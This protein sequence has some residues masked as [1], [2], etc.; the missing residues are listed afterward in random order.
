M[1]RC[2][3]SLRGLGVAKRFKESVEG[4]DLVSDP[5]VARR[6]EVSGE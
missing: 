3:R 4:F 6:D 1:T 2:R 5:E